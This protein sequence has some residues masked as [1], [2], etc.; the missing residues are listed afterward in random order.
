M[1]VR[2]LSLDNDFLTID[3]KYALIRF[4]KSMSV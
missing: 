3:N 2:E 1:P 4:V